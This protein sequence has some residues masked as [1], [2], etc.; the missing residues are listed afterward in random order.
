MA[1]STAN[2]SDLLVVG[3]G[4]LG[5][6][7][8]KLWKESHPECVVVGQT[9]STSNHDRCGRHC[10]IIRGAIL[11]FSDHCLLMPLSCEVS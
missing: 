9:N 6:Y 4:V 11:V 7:A 1:A 5:G 2:P 8:G 3:P 10:I